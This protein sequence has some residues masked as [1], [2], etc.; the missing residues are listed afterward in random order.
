VSDSGHFLSDP[1]FQDG[2]E[3]LLLDAILLT[4]LALVLFLTARF[5]RSCSSF[6]AYTFWFAVFYGNGWTSLV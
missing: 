6:A 2:V 3:F 5:L 4:L 1:K